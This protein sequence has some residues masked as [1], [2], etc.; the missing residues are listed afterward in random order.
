MTKGSRH[1][2]AS[3]ALRHVRDARRLTEGAAPSFDQAWHLAGFGPEC[4][5]KA[6]LVDKAAHKRLGH[7]LHQPELLAW[8]LSIDTRA[9]RSVR[10]HA[11]TT[12]WQP[13]H[14]YERIWKLPVSPACCSTRTLER[15]RGLGHGRNLL[16]TAA[17]GSG[18][19]ELPVVP[20]TVHGVSFDLAPAGVLTPTYVEKLARLDS[21]S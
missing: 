18:L 4:A 12:D 5:R 3:A 13:D 21:A 1:A 9:A 11:P 16:S 2:M 8:A 19:D 14:R 10:R 6:A 7:D 20:V 17:T 15:I